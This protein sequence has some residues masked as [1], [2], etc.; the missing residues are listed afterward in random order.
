[1]DTTPQEADEPDAICTT[2]ACV[3]AAAQILQNLSPR[4]HDLD[5]CTN[6]DQYVCEGFY[7]KHDIRPDQS[8]VSTAAIMSETGDQ[9]LRHLLEAPF[10]EIEPIM[11]D[12]V[13]SSDRAIFEKLQASYAACLDEKLL[14]DIGIAPMAVFYEDIKAL[15]PVN[16]T[17]TPEGSIFPQ[18]RTQTQ[19]GIVNEDNNAITDV[20]SYLISIGTSALIDIGVSADDKDPDVVVPFVYAPRSPGLPS[21]EYYEDADIVARYTKA[22]QQTHDAFLKKFNLT[23]PPDM[24]D[25]VLKLE[26][27]IARALPDA[28]DADDV[29]FYYNPM[30]FEQAKSLLPQVSLEHLVKSLAPHAPRPSKLIIAAPQYLRD[31]SQILKETSAETL[32]AYF[33]KRALQRYVYKVEDDAVK[34][35]KRFN[36]EL[37]GKDPDAAEERWRTCVKVADGGLGWILSRFFV[38]KAFSEESRVFGDNIVSD[39]KVQFV[40]RLKQVEW[41]SP[42]VRQLGIEKG[43]LPSRSTS[44]LDGS[45]FPS[46]LY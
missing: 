22:T 7:E 11:A 30:T 45:G 23:A 15:Y 32:L 26:A 31:L 33:L 14:E 34:P 3:L 2:P 19:L 9:L 21:K 36:N 1:M 24:A 44:D 37:Q 38:Q 12:S 42:E 6:F 28:E 20:I 41:M 39:I 13:T 18:L 35:L 4:R 25:H 29:T 43:E 27:K 40:E 16:E 10:T 8:G 17:Y 5:P 46:Y